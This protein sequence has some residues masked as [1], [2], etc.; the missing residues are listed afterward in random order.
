MS[1]INDLPV[2]NTSAFATVKALLNQQDGLC[3]EEFN[4]FMLSKVN[5]GVTYQ[6][7]EEREVVIDSVESAIKYRLCFNMN[8]LDLDS[9]SNINKGCLLKLK[10]LGL[11]YTIDEINF[12]LTK[13]GLDFIDAMQTTV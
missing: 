12:G 2:D 5:E 4:S 8:D 13:L 10:N 9:N 6:L 11:I 3:L 7:S 1:W